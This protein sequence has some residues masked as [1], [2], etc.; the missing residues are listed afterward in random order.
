MKPKFKFFLAKHSF[1][2]WLLI[3]IVICG[4]YTGGLALLES[5]PWKYIVLNLLGMLCAYMIVFSAPSSI[6][7]PAIRALTNDCNPNPLLEVTTELLN[8]KLNQTNKIITIINYSAALLELGRAREAIDVLIKLSIEEE[9]SV[10]PAAKLAYYVNV[11]NGYF[12]LLDQENANL[13]YKKAVELTD[14]LKSKKAKAQFESSL[15]P[16]KL[17]NLY[18]NQQYKE[19]IRLT[20]QMPS[21]NNRRQVSIDYLSALAY[22]KLGNL[23]QAK[24]HLNEVI[25]NGNFLNEKAIAAEL[26]FKLENEDI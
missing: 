21:I 3:S 11:S 16:T 1:L 24:A 23:V 15:A 12:Q 17:E 19:L 25:K 14:G 9:K 18:I 13:F 8:Y 22:I 6:M 26:L 7:R 10:T 20:N 5:E 2:G 4:I